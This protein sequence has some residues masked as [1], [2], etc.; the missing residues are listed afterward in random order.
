MKL[1]A[2]L[3]GSQALEIM[4]SFVRCFLPLLLDYVDTASL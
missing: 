1:T 4:R 3:K 2:E